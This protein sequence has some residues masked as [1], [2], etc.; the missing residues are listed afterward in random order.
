MFSEES[1]IDVFFSPCESQQ[2]INGVTSGQLYACAHFYF[3]YDRNKP[4]S[5]RIMVT[6]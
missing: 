1:K 6:S 3:E 4:G 5:T 2:L